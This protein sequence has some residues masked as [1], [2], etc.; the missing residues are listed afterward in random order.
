MYIYN[1]F[2]TGQR[3][4]MKTPEQPRRSSSGIPSRRF[5]AQSEQWEHQNCV[6]SVQS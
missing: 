5:L 6:K 4:V 2:G 1:I 3:L